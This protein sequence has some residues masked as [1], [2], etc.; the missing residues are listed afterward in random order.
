MV[1]QLLVSLVDRLAGRT[2]K[3]LRLQLWLLLAFFLTAFAAS[4][5]LR[6][7]ISLLACL[8]LLLFTWLV[9]SFVARP[10][11]CGLRTTSGLL[12]PGRGL[13]VVARVLHVPCEGLVVAQNLATDL[14][15]ALLRVASLS[16]VD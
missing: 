13:L 11:L 10:L 9:A 14:T 16:L 6:L 1:F 4:F 2:L 8:M 15:S 5:G 3:N 12:F 7:L